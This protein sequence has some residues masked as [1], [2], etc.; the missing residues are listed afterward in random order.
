MTP[1][2]EGNLV[3][4]VHT[5]WNK[6]TVEQRIN[7]LKQSDLDNITDE[8]KLWFELDEV[9]QYAVVEWFI[10]RLGISTPRGNKN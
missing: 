6:M 7:F 5:L 10:A 8:S 1:S 2:L 3:D 9:Q 4:I